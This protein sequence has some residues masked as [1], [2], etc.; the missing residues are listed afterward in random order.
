M[1]TPITGPAG[2]FTYD[3]RSGAWTWS[4]QVFSVFGFDPGDVVPSTAL[5][6]HHQHPE[7]RPEVARVLRDVIETGREFCLWHRVV[8]AHA[9]THLVLSVGAGVFAEDGAL[10]ATQGFLVDL[11][12]GVRRTA[13]REVDEAMEQ[14]MQSRPSIER[15]KGGLMMT[16]ALDAD[17]AFALLRR[18]SQ[19]CNV[20]VRDVARDLVQ[21]MSHGDLPEG[22]RA[23]WDKLAARMAEEG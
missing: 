17:A 10:T 18:Y 4:D 2:S 11:T 9:N 1:T 6:L 12:E 23:T 21:A 19:L 7:D 13:A 8:D 15:A 20:K 3:H 22:T 16:Y 14:L 5:A